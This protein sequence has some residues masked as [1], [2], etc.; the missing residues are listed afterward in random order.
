M[1][2]AFTAPLIEVTMQ[3]PTQGE[4]AIIRIALIGF[5]LCIAAVLS[6]AW[7]DGRRPTF[8]DTALDA[9]GRPLAGVIARGVSPTLAAPLA[10]SGPVCAVYC[11][12]TRRWRDP[13]TKRFVRAP[14]GE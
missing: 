1:H 8:M 10:L 14:T 3:D 2:F 12:R 4:S 7:A 9:I 5:C 11:P 6:A 13:V